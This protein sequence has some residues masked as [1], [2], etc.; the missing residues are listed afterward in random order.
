MMKKEP[1][2]SILIANYNNGKYLM[3]AVESVRR[4][5]YANWEIVLVD[6]GSNDNS[7]E[8]YAELEKDERIHIYRN[9]KNMGC[10]YTKHRC[11]DLANGEICGFLDPDDALTEN[12]LEL[13]VKI[14]V[15]HPEVSI[16]Y[17]KA[18]LCDTN[19]TVFDRVKLP[20]FKGKTYFDHRWAGCMAFASFKRDAYRKTKG[21]NPKAMAGIDQD[22]YFK[23]EEVG[24]IYPLDEFTYY[25][26][27]KGH[28][29]SITTGRGNYGKLWYWNM[30]ARYE[31]CK[32]RGLDADTI[33][34]KDFDEALKNYA[35]QLVADKQKDIIESIVND[36]LE[37]AMY[38]REK[39]VRS[40]L[41]YRVGYAILKPYRWMQRLLSSKK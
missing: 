23:L 31:A 38:Q 14:H 41:T 10:G 21:V 22:L 39:E 32:R 7:E 11:A 5:T 1:L 40:T 27:V 24:E 15:E 13:E 29:D 9:E 34:P 33:M 6:D 28:N 19:F 18:Y 4:Q 30:L 25:Y 36:R 3:D 8:V 37:E 16:V 17:S 12:A 35:D 26:V 20:D 2:F